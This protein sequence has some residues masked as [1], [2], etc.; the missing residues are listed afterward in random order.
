MLDDIQTRSSRYSFFLGKSLE[1]NPTAGTDAPENVED[2]LKYELDVRNNIITTKTIQPNDSCLVV[3]RINWTSGTVYDTYDDFYQESTQT[4][5]GTISATTSSDTVTGTNTYFTSEVA[6]GDVIKTSAGTTVGTVESIASNTSL[7]LAANSA[8]AASGAYTYTHTVEAESGATAIEDANFYVLTEDYNVY[9]CIWNNLGAESTVKPTGTGTG[10]LSTSD[11]YVWKYMY[12]IPVALRNKFLIT[13]YMPVTTALKNQYYNQGVISTINIISGGSSYTSGTTVTVTGDGYLEDNPYIVSTTVTIT[14][15]GSG[16]TSTPTVTFSAPTVTSGPEV[17]ATGTAALTAG[18][19]SGITVTN[20]GYG[21]AAAPTITVSEPVTPDAVWEELTAFT[22]G[23]IIYYGN[24][25]YEVT[26]GGT[27]STT[28]P[29]HTSGAVTNGTAQ[30]TFTAARATATAAVTK[31]E[32]LLTPVITGG[33]ITDINIVD[34][35]V[36]Y[37]YATVTVTDGT[38]SGADITVDLAGGNIDTIQSNVEL[39]AVNGDLS[40]I[41]VIDGGANYT[42]APTVTITGDGTGATATAT[43]EDGAVTKVILTAR[44]TGYTKATVA[45]SNGGGSGATARA[46]ISPKGGHGKNSVKELYAKDIMFYSTISNELNQGFTVNNDYR[47]LGIIRNLTQYGSTVRYTGSVGSACFKTVGTVNTANF[48]V[49][50][51]VNIVGETK[52][53]R[54]VALT[55]SGTLLQSLDN[56]TPTAGDR[57]ENADED[58]FPVSS[59]VAPSIDKFSGELLYIDNRLAFTPTTEQ[60]ITARAIF[61]L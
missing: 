12:N 19:V 37:T 55:S 7:T 23:D 32:A 56:D 21:Y 59:V 39:L 61:R 3:R 25:Y 8:V 26:T 47:Q 53:F 45:F 41:K 54:I 38:G 13:G 17:T 5:S 50:E 33:E 46:V 28:A 20:I 43:V 42:S 6:V 36:G 57:F 10:Y 14:S 31:S 58:Q 40:C 16:Y 48:T 4:G 51:E 29:T 60:Q 11:G 52:E 15:G 30:L 1:W 18:A 44:G 49:D 35:G 2:H 34:G 9:K 24:N 22:T 27:T